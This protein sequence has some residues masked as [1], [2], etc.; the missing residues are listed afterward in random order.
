MGDES[1][2]E[3]VADLFLID[4]PKQ[5]GDYTWGSSRG[6]GLWSRLDCWLNNEEALLGF[7]GVMQLQLGVS[8]HRAVVLNW[9]SKDFR[10]KPFTFYNYWLMEVGFKDMVEQR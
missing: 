6:D 9:G 4:L 5:N 7:D 3:F 8:D 1:F 10:P 2:K